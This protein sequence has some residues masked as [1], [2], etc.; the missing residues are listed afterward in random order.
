MLKKLEDLIT[1]DPRERGQKRRRERGR[2]N[3]KDRIAQQDLCDDS[4]LCTDRRARSLPQSGDLAY[5]HRFGTQER[6]VPA[7]AGRSQGHRER[8]RQFGRLV[9]AP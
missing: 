9:D 5:G 7:G 3:L 4:T 2:R 8:D 1:R 6:S